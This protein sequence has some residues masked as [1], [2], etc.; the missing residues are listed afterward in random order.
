MK[1]SPTRTALLQDSKMQEQPQ[2]Y[3]ARQFRRLEAQISQRFCLDYPQAVLGQVW[4]DLEYL[5]YNQL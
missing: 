4:M 1:K 3:H 2:T 5:R